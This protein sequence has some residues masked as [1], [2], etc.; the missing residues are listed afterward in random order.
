MPSLVK[1]H[2]GVDSLPSL[3]I[4]DTWS[5]KWFNY[6]LQNWFGPRDFTNIVDGATTGT[7]TASFTATNKPGTTNA[8]SPALWVPVTYKGT[9]Y[10]MPLFSA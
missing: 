4:P 9:V 8:T 3:L 7:K 6:L 5:S 10:Y 2:A 1:I